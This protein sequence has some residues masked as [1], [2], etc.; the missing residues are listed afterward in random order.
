MTG[1]ARQT[2]HQVVTALFLALGV[3]IG[4][5]LVGGLSA[6][7]TGR[8]PIATIQ[9]LART[10]KLWAIVV[11]IGGSFPTIQ[12]IESGLFSGQPGVLMRQVVVIL[13]SLAG[14]QLGQWIVVT[15]TGG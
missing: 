4:G 10:I 2:L 12:A 13:A 15:V 11:A 7:A 1:D 3:V 8:P 14:A 5:S 9:E 6:L